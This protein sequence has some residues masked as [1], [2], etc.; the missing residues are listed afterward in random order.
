MNLEE[1]HHGIRAAREV[2]ARQGGSGE[3]VIMGSQ[4][5]LAAYSPAALDRRL[6][7]SAEVD[8]MPVADDPA[9]IERLADYLHGA[10]GQDSLFQATHGF[11]VDGIS[12]DTS[13][14]PSGWVH[15]LIPAVDPSSG[16]T[17]WCLDPHDLA[18]AKMIAGRAKDLDFV[19]ILIE[20]RLI[21][22]LVVRDG[23]SSVDDDRTVVAISRLDAM[24]TSGLPESER[25]AWHRRRR[26][27]MRDR[28]T[29]TAEMSP[30]QVLETLMEGDG[31]G[32][33]GEVL[34]P[35]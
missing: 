33:S 14:L 22:P 26:Q 25:A 6:L 29:R 10:L 2:L 32:G 7:F 8:V 17:G 19:R 31:S 15:R 35:G 20:E 3:L 11:H 23:L 4:S 28:M 9:E 16:A 21:D 1:F 5:I 30:V 34:G 18:V 27:A 13:V 12:I 24:A